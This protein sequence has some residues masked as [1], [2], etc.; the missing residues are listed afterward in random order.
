MDQDRYEQLEHFVGKLTSA[1]LGPL[2]VNTFSAYYRQVVDGETGIIPDDAI[3]PPYDGEIVS[4]E[5]LDSYHDDGRSAF[6]HAVRITLNGGL[7]TSM[8]LTGP[9]SLL[10]VKDGKTFLEVII[11]QSASSGVRQVLM[12]SFSTEAATY[13]ALEDLAPAD[14]PLMFTQN[15]F[16]KI[17]QDTLAPADW[18]TNRDLEWNPPGHGDIYTAM[19]ASGML[20][21]LLEQNIR[22]ALI[23]NSDNLGASMDARILGYF[24]RRDLPFL[25]EVARRTPA[26]AKGGHL[27]VN[28]KGGLILRE[29]AQF[30]EQSQGRNIDTYSY[31]NTNNLWISLPALKKLV[32]R[33][34]ILK[35]PLI[36][37]PKTLDPRDSN[38]PAVFQ[39]ETAMG[40]AIELFEDAGAVQVTRSRFFPVKT[41]NDLLAVRSDSYQL[42]Q[43]LILEPNPAMVPPGPHIELDPRYYKKI[44]MF[45]AR[46]PQ[47]APSLVRCKR[48]ILKGDILF[49]QGVSIVGDITITNRQDR[50]A[51]IKAGTVIDQDLQL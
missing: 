48:L 31:F 1:G 26:D 19:A 37:N 3:R 7:G 47:G 30:P 14:P 24:A 25:M 46:F 29:S 13:E 49:E 23:C 27:A 10:S 15:R 38:S 12:N 34:K 33:E 51:V 35:L 8:G 18:P 39:V 22:Y 45:D 41:C 50:Q 28:R 36:L 21:R 16:P 42:N 44:D 5:D 32:A 4:A 17:L 40:A 43:D 11:G 20:D 9:K 6:Q 2:V